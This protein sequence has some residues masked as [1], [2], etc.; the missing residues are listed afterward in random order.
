MQRQ[1]ASSSTSPRRSQDI[2]GVHI[3]CVRSSGRREDKRSR[4]SSRDN[5]KAVSRR[6]RHRSHNGVT[7][8]GLAKCRRRRETRRCSSSGNLDEE[9]A[10]NLATDRQQR[11]RLRSQA[12]VRSEKRQLRVHCT[13][14]RRGGGGQRHCSGKT[15]RK[16]SRESICSKRSGERGSNNTSHRAIAHVRSSTQRQSR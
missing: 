1:C 16:R 13:A 10:G 9:C 15:K 7:I 12:R 11:E 6:R 2:A 4:N 3:A 8:V 14:E 5:T